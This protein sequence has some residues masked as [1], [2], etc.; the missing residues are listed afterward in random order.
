MRMYV[1]PFHGEG[2]PIGRVFGT[3]VERKA[4][5]LKGSGK[6]IVTIHTPNLSDTVR[7]TWQ[8]SHH[9]DCCT[10]AHVDAV[11]IQFHLAARRASHP[12]E[13]SDAG[14]R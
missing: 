14:H 4:T 3:V 13:T 11:C 9:M 1:Y 12:Q 10:I 8:P 2:R 5:C 6:V 7:P